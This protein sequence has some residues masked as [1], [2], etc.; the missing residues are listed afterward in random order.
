MQLE[1]EKLRSSELIVSRTDFDAM[2]KEN[3]ESKQSLISLTAE[4][5]HLQQYNNTLLKR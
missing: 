1:K 5:R 4:R 3:R 2:K